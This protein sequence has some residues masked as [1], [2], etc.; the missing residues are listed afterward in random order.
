[1]GS[2]CLQITTEATP[3][4]QYHHVSPSCC[5]SIFLNLQALFRVTVSAQ[6]HKVC[7]VS[8]GSFVRVPLSSSVHIDHCVTSSQY[9]GAEEHGCKPG[10][11]QLHEQVGRCPSNSPT[12]PAGHPGV[13]YSASSVMSGQV[14]QAPC[15]SQIH[16]LTKIMLC[17]KGTRLT[18][19]LQ[20]R[21]PLA[22]HGGKWTDCHHLT[23]LL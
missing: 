10:L 22:A 5:H 16:P 1:M 14:A 8:N 21:H 23:S 17:V 6:Q 13:Q 20:S 2:Q 4:I 3:L 9:L 15:L 7:Q 19:C 12:A 18:T 11:Q